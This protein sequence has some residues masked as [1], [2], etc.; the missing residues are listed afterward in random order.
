[1]ERLPWAYDIAS[2][3]QCRCGH[4]WEDH[5]AAAD[6]HACTYC[7]CLQPRLVSATS[8]SPAMGS[9][10]TPQLDTPFARLSQALCDHR[11][12][13]TGAD[14]EAQ[15]EALTVCQGHISQEFERLAQRQ[16]ESRL[17]GFA[18]CECGR[19]VLNAPDYL[20]LRLCVLCMCLGLLVH[21]QRCGEN[22]PEHHIGGRGCDMFVHPDEPA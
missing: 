3:A 6:A 10:P 19:R 2:A 7:E 14:L 20:R 15:H 16:Y 17:S 22:S 5:I 11:L 21:C 4:R 1:M 8:V 12:A 13:L 9:T 18:C